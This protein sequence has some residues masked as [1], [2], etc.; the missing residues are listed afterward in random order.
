MKLA[1]VITRWVVEKDQRTPALLTELQPGDSAMDVTGQDA[2]KLPGNHNVVVWE[3]WVADKNTTLD[4][5]NAD[6]NVYVDVYAEN[7]EKVLS[8][9]DSTALIPSA[10]F[11][12]LRDYLAGIGI[13]EKDVDA[14]VDTTAKQRTRQTVCASLRQWCITGPKVA[15]SDPSR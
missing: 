3:L 11:A 12:K 4:R 10:E 8:D 14:A 13:V 2:L 7:G 5:L 9:K 1:T 15:E 6:A